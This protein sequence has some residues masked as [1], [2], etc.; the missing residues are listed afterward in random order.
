MTCTSRQAAK[1]GQVKDAISAVM[2]STVNTA[3]SN[4]RSAS[5]VRYFRSKYSTA[6]ATVVTATIRTGDISRKA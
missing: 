6:A 5:S 1:S 3:A 4:I 2:D